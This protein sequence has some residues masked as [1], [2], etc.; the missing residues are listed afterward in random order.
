MTHLA[1]ATPTA[2]RIAE[3]KAT[4]ALF[5]TKV[6]VCKLS[7]SLRNAVRVVIVSG[8]RDTVRDAALNANTVSTAGRSPT[9][10]D[11]ANSFNG[12]EINLYFLAA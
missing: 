1:I 10:P 5:G 6:R 7:G 3:L 8:D 2:D 4:C 11:F 12:D 9:S